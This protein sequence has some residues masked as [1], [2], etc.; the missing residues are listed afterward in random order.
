MSD[1]SVNSSDER[2]RFLKGAIGGIA[3]F[4]I[5][6]TIVAAIVHNVFNADNPDANLYSSLATALIITW[7]IVL[8]SF[9]I[10]AVQ[11]YNVNHGWSMKAWE[12]LANNESPS[13]ENAPKD[14]PHKTESLGLPNG[15][16]RATIAIS[17]MVGGLAMMIASLGMPDRLKTNE[18]FIDNFEFFKT[19]FL[20]MIAFYF[21]NKS[22]DFLKDRKQVFGGP[23][24]EE[25]KSEFDVNDSQG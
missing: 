21:G 20:M 19:A 25:K 18:F 24:K 2:G 6:L 15:T 3:A 23:K 8:I 16:V 1:D 5:V 7:I 17:L 9:Y 4:I 13:A 14:N 10:W 11:F 22:L 12:R